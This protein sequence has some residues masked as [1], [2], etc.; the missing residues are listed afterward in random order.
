MRLLVS[1]RSAAEV[2]AAVRGGADIVDAKEP[3]R[4]S[5]GAVSPST[6]RDISRALPGRVPLS[7]ALGDPAGAPEAA[8]AVGTALDAAAPRAGPM[9][10]KLGLAR[11]GRRGADVLRSAVEAAA[12]G[13]AGVRVVLATY[14]D[15]SAATV[16]ARESAIS[17]AV[18]A[19]AHGMLL[20]TWGKDGR[21]L[22]HHVSFEALGAW[23]ALCRRHGLLVAL[24]GSLDAHGVER[25]AAVA[26]DV[27]GVRGAA[28]RGGREGTV[29]EERVR[30]LREALDWSPMNLQLVTD[31]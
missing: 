15:R 31:K 25:A 4:G 12:D 18:E 17:L 5:I 9:Y 29:D 14:A 13:G 3:S 21:T 10:L 22:L 27:V 16:A 1:V 19:G 28:C 23:T 6:L 7:V 30:S 8:R 11:A 20:D 2:P 24:A 26:P